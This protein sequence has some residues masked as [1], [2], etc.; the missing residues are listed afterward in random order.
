MSNTKDFKVA[1]IV[2]VAGQTTLKTGTTSTS[3]ENYRV[4]DLDNEAV[5][6]TIA[7]L[8]TPSNIFFKADGLQ[9]FLLDGG[10]DRVKRLSLSTAWDVTSTLTLVDSK[11]VSSQ[12]TTPTWVQLSDTGRHMFVLSTSADTVYEYD[13]DPA[14]DISA[15]TFTQS[16]S[17]V[18]GGGGGFTSFAFN[19]DGTKIFFTEGSNTT[20]SFY[21][22]STP[23]DISSVGAE[24]TQ[25]ISG[26][27]GDGQIS[28][29]DNGSLMLWL[30]ITNDNLLLFTL[31]TAYDLS[32]ATLK[33]TKTNIDTDLR[34]PVFGDSGNNVIFVNRID[35]N[36]YAYD[37]E[38]D[39]LSVDLSTGNY[40][41]V[42][43][44]GYEELSFTNPP[45]SQTFQVLQ[46]GGTGFGLD[47]GATANFT[48]GTSAIPYYQDTGTF[49]F[50]LTPDGRHALS[51]ETNQVR[52]MELD[53]PFDLRAMSLVNYVTTP[54]ANSKGRY[55]R[56]DG[57]YAYITTASSLRQY[58][59][60]PPFTGTI[61]Q[62]NNNSD[63]VNAERLWFKPD[64]TRFFLSGPVSNATISTFD[65]TTPWDIS[66]ASDASKN[67]ALAVDVTNIGFILSEDGTHLY[68]GTDT[69][70]DRI[71]N[72]VLTTPWDVTSAALVGSIELPSG[73]SL[74]WKLAG[75]YPSENK[76]VL[77]S[78][79]VVDTFYESLF[80]FYTSGVTY[81]A[82][83][84]RDTVNFTGGAAPTYNEDSNSKLITFSTN[85]GGATYYAGYS[86][87]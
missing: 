39:V 28:F 76:F 7:D 80:E 10:A 50:T 70:P 64:G 18:P 74:N 31:S 51:F 85:D 35:D 77:T 58:E 33:E 78:S 53:K 37:A 79:T 15:A 84:Y 54:S 30:D 38:V 27:T 19:D 34:S 23:Y 55:L 45:V 41:E 44:S 86:D 13:V 68:Y 20:M 48:S 87:V 72:Y 43:T 60:D 8:S 67:L 21:T 83:V 32:T 59:I 9:V 16:Q 56:N 17:F 24:S 81:Y 25:A 42:D 4:I 3:Q 71:F 5:S 36:L 47:V 22:L 66:T 65:L 2:Q 46:K 82:P 52:L 73:I 14:Y 75:M 26:A 57:R 40:F 69:T 11:S 6:S 62:V 29:A 1:D 49:E 12:T 61:T 63:L